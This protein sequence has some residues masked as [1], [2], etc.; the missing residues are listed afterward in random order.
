MRKIALIAGCSQSAGSEI[1]GSQ[2][3]RYNRD[4][5]FGNILASKLGYEPINIAVSGSTNTGIA[6]SIQLWFKEQYDS[7]TMEVFVIVGWTEGSRLEVP[8]PRLGQNYRSAN[9]DADWYD[10]TAGDY[11]RLNFGWDG[12]NPEEI[13]II[14]RY[15]RFMVENP[16]ILET[17]S[18]NQILLIQYFLKSLNVD[19]VMS[20]TMHL[21]TPNVYLTHYLDMI[22][23][24]HYYDLDANDQ[25]S[26]YW[27]YRNMGHINEKAKYWHHSEEPHRLYAEEL[28]TFIKENKNDVV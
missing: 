20:H 17:T 9:L 2:D 25:T 1:D 3:S 21:C 4:N 16:T 24:S 8:S 13:E 6:R 11:Y 12:N 19:Y 14:S 15:R 22:D 10:N 26:F 18:I 27:K 7:N 28:Y 5:S 23:L